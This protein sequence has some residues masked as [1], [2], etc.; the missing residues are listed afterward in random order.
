MPKNNWT[1]KVIGLSKSV[2]LHDKLNV[3]IMQWGHIPI[4]V[5]YK[6][7]IKTIYCTMRM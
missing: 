2:A 3:C 1:I 6:L 5:G 7:L 4:Q